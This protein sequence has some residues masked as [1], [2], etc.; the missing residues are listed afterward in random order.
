MFD[1]SNKVIVLVGGNGILGSNIFETFIKKESKVA[2]ID[3][4]FDKVDKIINLNKSS[5]KNNLKIR[6]NIT[7]ENEVQ[8]SL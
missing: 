5:T 3:G 7:K 4:Y 8:N 6:T 2:V 1:L